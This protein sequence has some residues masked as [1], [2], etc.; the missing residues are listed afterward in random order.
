LWEEHPAEMQATLERHDEILRASI[1]CRDGHVFAATGEGFAVA[2]THA[3]DALD[4]A[5]EIQRGL[6]TEHWPGALQ[7]AVRMGLYTG[8]ASERN[9]IYV[10]PVLNRAARI[11]A[12]GHGGQILVGAPTVSLIEEVDFIDL[13]EHRFKDLARA[14][15]VFQVRAEGLRS[16]FPA[17]RTL[18]ARR[19]NLPAPAT[20][21][22]GRARELAEIVDLV[23]ANRL[24]TLTGV[25]GVGKTRLALEV[26]AEM[27]GQFPDGVWLVELA[28]VGEAASVP[29]AIATA[30]GLTPQGGVP[31]THT[32]AEALS[33][34]RLLMLLDNCEHVVE[35][36]A[37]AVQAIL[38]RSGTATVLA[39]SR[40]G[41]RVAG[42]H[43]M[44]VPPLALDG[45]ATSPA[46]AL[47]VERARAVHPGFDLDDLANAEAV[48]E[49][50]RGLDGLAL[51]IE[52]AAARMVSLTPVDLQQ[53]LLV[54]RF[55]MLTGSKRQR[56]LRQTVGWSYDLL[57]DEECAVLRYASVFSGGFG[58]DA[59]TDVVGADDPLDVLDWLDSLVRKSLVTVS[60]ATGLVRYSLLETIRQFAEEELSTLG[61]LE[62]T[63]DCHARYFAREVMA[64]W[65]RWNG[66]GFR[67]AV[68]WVEVEFSNLRAAFRWSAARNDVETA[69]DIAAHSAVI[70]VSA[71]LFETV[72][73]VEEIIDAATA[74]D[75]RRLPCVYAAAGYSCFTGRPEQAVAYA[76]TAVLL[77][78]NPKYD[79]FVPGLAGLIE[80]LAQV[81][82]GHLDR[83]VE[84]TGGIAALPGARAFGLPA[85]VDGLQATGRVDEAMELVE[86]AVAVARNL[87]NPWFIAY[88]LWI[89][90]SVYAH[91]D[92]AR[93]RTAWREGLAYVR[94]H[95]VDFF[96]GF[97]ARDAAI[98]KVV[99]A[100]PEESLVLIDAAIDSFRQAGNIAQ[101][102][103]TLASL[104]SLLERIDCSEGA[105]TLY[106]A[107]I[108]Q[109][110]SE[111][112]VPDLPD[113][114]TRI[115]SKLGSDR[116]DE[117]ASVG[118]TMDLTA[119]AHYAR[120]QIQLARAQLATLATRPGQPAALSRR[121]VEVLRLVAEGLT[122]R[123]IAD[124]LYIS[125]KTADHHIQ[126]VY[127]KIG[128]SNRASAALWAFQ[129]D[130]I[131]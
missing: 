16:E 4:S 85:Y 103:I 92:P 1:E 60:H 2:F 111:R 124:R 129:H 82:S 73:W 6:A 43:L 59:I 31:V 63:R 80:A 38:A 128:V 33:G 7:L 29:D 105:G 131:D 8:E 53:R 20:S 30:L 89:R 100:D 22:I 87:G 104:T 36:A 127:T 46:V 66:P 25:G 109:P 61:T 88:S 76:H 96:E 98:L 106:G 119:T 57:D 35:A 37:D 91:V 108:C 49:I 72:G 42:E 120:E 9:G 26:G 114:A 78:E 74:A 122:T 14:E 19:G 130:V 41:L 12:A 21:L 47:F 71:E 79:P 113:V 39:T 50:C 83:Y 110:G 15:R 51:A 34:R 121:E 70:G 95:R 52:L 40:E 23:R 107:I 24:V 116:F 93:A 28:P 101:L 54:D 126:H 32:I 65:L 58:L 123:E 64:R 45:G 125:A 55:R 75:V 3:R 97:I 68:D 10:G 62:P 81:Y 5:V 86:E 102:T 67:D 94:Q 17:L 13:G 115:A 69:A 117:C 99:D 118:Q 18:D 11:M 84:I 112:H 77:E 48:T 90:G 27:A 56:S 44:P